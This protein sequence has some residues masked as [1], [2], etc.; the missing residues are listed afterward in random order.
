MNIFILDLRWAADI[1]LA[2]SD[3]YD[4]DNLIIDGLDNF[5]NRIAEPLK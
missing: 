5:T 2:P 4:V 1:I 3:L